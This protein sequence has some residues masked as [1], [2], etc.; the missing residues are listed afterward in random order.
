MI[1]SMGQSGPCSLPGKRHQSLPHHRWLEK[2]G[3]CGA[4]AWWPESYITFQRVIIST[5]PPDM[6]LPAVPPPRWIQAR[7][8]AGKRMQ[9]NCSI[10]F[11]PSRYADRT[12]FMQ[13]QIKHINRH[14]AAKLLEATENLFPLLSRSPFTAS[15]LLIKSGGR[16]CACF[17]RLTIPLMPGCR[18]TV[19]VYR[20]M[21]ALRIPSCS[22]RLY[23][24]HSCQTWVRWKGIGNTWTCSIGTGNPLKRRKLYLFWISL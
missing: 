16:F 24:M 9:T 7:N 10:R 19:A 18:L 11:T 17:A 23:Y 20:A 15:G 14:L 5:N 6:G 1:I 22:R 12:S 3:G 8:S 4:T 21:G 13:G 2:H